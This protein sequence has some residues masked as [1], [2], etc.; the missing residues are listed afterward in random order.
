M[1]KKRFAL[2]ILFCLMPTLSLA[3]DPGISNY[4]CNPKSGAES[5]LSVL[6]GGKYICT[7]TYP[8][9]K[10]QSFTYSN[11]QNNSSFAKDI[12]ATMVSDTDVKKLP[13]S[14]QRLAAAKKVLSARGMDPNEAQSII[15]YIDQE[16]DSE[17]DESTDSIYGHGASS[18]MDAVSAE[19]IGYINDTLKEASV[20]AM[21]PSKT[22][23]I[24]SDELNSHSDYRKTI[25]AIL[26]GI[27]TL[28]PAY[29]EQVN[30][31]TNYINNLGEITINNDLVKVYYPDHTKDNFLAKNIDKMVRFLL[32]KDPSEQI[33]QFK[34]VEFMDQQVLGFMVYLIASIHAGYMNVL[35][36]VFLIGV[37]WLITSVFGKA[38]FA[39]ILIMRQGGNKSKLPGWFQKEKQTANPRTEKHIAMAF[40][41]VFF[42]APSFKMPVATTGSIEKAIYKD[43]E[44]ESISA[45]SYSTPAQEF[46]RY[47]VQAGNYF[48]NET[49]D[50][51]MKAYIALLNFK[52][53]FVKDG[54]PKMI[55]E[56]NDEIAQ[57]EADKAKLAASAALYNN[58]CKPYKDGEK[59]N[60]PTASQNYLSASQ[61]SPTPKK[62]AFI[63][64][65][66]ASGIYSAINIDGAQKI[67]LSSDTMNVNSAINAANNAVDV[68]A[69][70]IIISMG[71]Q[72]ASSAPSDMETWKDGFNN[73][74]NEVIIPLKENGARVV[75]ISPAKTSNPDLNLKVEA[76]KSGFRSAC[77]TTVELP[78]LPRSEM[79]S[80]GIYPNAAGFNHIAQF[81]TPK[82]AGVKADR[83]DAAACKA[84]ED[85][86]A[87]SSKALMKRATIAAEKADTIHGFATNVKET[88]GTDASTLTTDPNKVLNKNRVVRGDVNWYTH[89]YATGERGTFGSG[90][91]GDKRIGSSNRNG[92][93]RVPMSPERPGWTAT[94]DVSYYGKADASGKLEAGTGETTASG[95][96]IRKVASSG[97]LV[98]ANWHLPLNTIVAV[99]AANGQTY[100]FRTIDRGP[101]VVIDKDGNR[102][103]R[104]P[105]NPWSYSTK[106]FDLTPK[107]MEELCMMTGDRTTFTVVAYNA[108]SGYNPVQPNQNPDGTITIDKSMCQKKRQL[109]GQGLT[110]TFGPT[111]SADNKT[112]L[113]PGDMTNANGSG[114]DYIVVDDSPLRSM[115]DFIQLVSFTNNN[116]GWMSAAMVPT[117]YEFFKYINMYYVQN[118]TGQMNNLD[119]VFAENT[120]GQFD[121]IAK[122]DDSSGTFDAFK[123][124]YKDLIVGNGMWF[125]IPGF[126]TIFSTIKDNLEKIVFA[127][128]RVDLPGKNGVKR[129]PQPQ[130]IAKNVLRAFVAGTL[131]VS[132]GGL[133]GFSSTGDAGVGTGK[134][135][136]VAM[137]IITALSDS[138]EA[139]KVMLFIIA[140]LTSISIV[141]FM[142]SVITLMSIT[143]FVV[144]KM[145]FYFMEV[146]LFFISAPIV[147]VKAAFDG[148]GYQYFTNFVQ[149]SLILMI[150]PLL[151]IIPIYLFIPI[152]ELMRGLFVNMLKAVLIVLENGGDVVG[153][154]G[155]SGAISKLTLIA[156][157]EGIIGVVSIFMT[158]IVTFIL[159]YKFRGWVM[160]KIGID[161]DIDMTNSAMGQ[162]KKSLNTYIAPI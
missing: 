53:G 159:I 5:R 158:F 115:K 40:A 55:G 87:V 100:N 64:D 143:V 72:D 120:Q 37:V 21:A 41:L 35:Y 154:T 62:V 2:H 124:V 63:G 89:G 47:C 52:M 113:Q 88:S 112:Y 15:D 155:F 103:V 59:F 118:A 147:G 107:A 131:S 44:V 148:N 91:Y 16:N 6:S 12:A 1:L 119:S 46:V 79:D 136:L 29:F 61:Q 157:M 140:F 65:K 30:G 144:M 114:V 25:P 19:K 123:Y 160:D 152:S 149:K 134:N 57:I 81:I 66:S 70:T 121:E 110:R 135:L 49:N 122:K 111:D 101:L 13:A 106:F 33:K 102:P 162:A 24:S 133:G 28:D 128:D 67:N 31:K 34:P 17:I 94:G 39:N 60:I 96:N 138:Y 26:S 54:L 93:F 150:T 76:I 69:D 137:S 86:I 74:L 105:E 104:G 84:L 9:G 92:F 77:G 3:Y 126:N 82:I 85:E 95:D 127:Q 7:Y 51:A 27:F 50:Y 4:K 151:I 108:P 11:P 56:T 80:N 68:N 18:A 99:K 153:A 42:L 109:M 116:F 48:A 90:L 98:A 73:A 45:Y 75:C 71:I 14:E 142:V 130:K 58:A 139:H 43:S 36:Y 8:D 83:I 10:E 97:A 22:I 125:V 78:V 32:K 161:D 141:V 129:T 156:S 23:N 132:S 38:S 145:I 146:I 20:L 117:S